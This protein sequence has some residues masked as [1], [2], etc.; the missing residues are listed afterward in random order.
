MFTGKTNTAEFA[1][2]ATSENRLGPDTANP[3]DRTLTPGGSSGGAAVSVAGGMSTVALGSDGG[4]SVRIPAAFTGLVGLKP[5]AGLCRDENGF[6]TMADFSSP[7]P[8]ARSVDD[9]RRV[10]TVLADTPF[11]RARPQPP[12]RVAW[13]P[14]PEGRPVASAIADAVSR[15]ACGCCRRPATEV[16]EVELPFDGWQE[17][18]GPFVLDT[19]QRC[20]G[21]P[22]GRPT[23]T[24]SHRTCVTTLQAA[25]RRADADGGLPRGC[26]AGVPPARGSL[27]RLRGHRGDADHRRATVS[28]RLAAAQR[29]GRADRWSVGAVPV[30]RAVQRGRRARAVAPV[31]R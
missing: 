11:S 12:L 25:R 6:V 14:R 9:V 30:H 2:S 13:C 31:R 19:E 28:H 27:L 5:S 15:A 26:T 17:L 16:E 8:L 29:G 22:A 21:S 1:Q 10:L 18:F 20:R 23:R 24:S 3:W 4:G 7:G